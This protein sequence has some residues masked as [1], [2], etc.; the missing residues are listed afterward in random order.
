MYHLFVQWPNEAVLIKG[1]LV[2]LLDKQHS[3]LPRTK[4]ALQKQ[5]QKVVAQNVWS[6]KLHF[7]AETDSMYA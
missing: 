6:A 2:F 4:D 3:H 1:Q 7:F 5:W